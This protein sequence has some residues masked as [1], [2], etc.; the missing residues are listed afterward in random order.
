MDKSV[1]S[2]V[3]G[4]AIGIL[5]SM[6]VTNAVDSAARASAAESAASVASMENTI[7]PVEA[8]ATAAAAHAAGTYLVRNDKLYLVTDDIAIGD[9]ITA[10]TNVKEVPGGIGGEVS[11][12]KSAI[13]DCAVSKESDAENVD[14]DVTDSN[15]NVIMRLA[16]GHIKTKNFD[17]VDMRRDVD[18]K[19]SD[20]SDDLVLCDTVGNV[21]AAFSDGHFQTKKFNSADAVSTEKFVRVIDGNDAYTEFEYDNTESSTV[22]VIGH[23]KAGDKI[24]CHFSNMGNTLTDS[25]SNYKATYGFI[26]SGGLM[27]QLGQ[28]YPYNF[29]CYTLPEDTEQIVGI[30]PASLLSSTHTCRFIVYRLGAFER[31]P[32][33]ITVAPDGSKMFTG[34]R[35]AMDSITN[36]N[37]YNRYEIWVY[38]GTY[39]VMSEYTGDEIEAEG[40]KGLFVKNGVT[41]VGIGHREEIIIHGELDTTDYDQTKRNDI[42]TLN[43]AGCCGLKNLTVTN[44]YLRYAVHDDHGSAT[45]QEQTHIVENCKF[46][47]RNA[48]SGGAGEAAYGAGGTNNKKLI[49]KNCDLG[50]R[51]IIHNTDGMTVPMTAIIQNS[52]AKIVTLTDNNSPNAPTRVEFDNCNIAIIRHMLSSGHSTAYMVLCGEGTH[53]VMMDVAAGVLYNFGDCVRFPGTVS[54]GQAVAITNQMQIAATTDP[55]I[56]YGIAIGNDG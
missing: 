48:A 33:I 40:F 9:T 56:I 55:T 21:M 5:K 27:S 30:F 2:K 13:S 12:L 10:G 11:E 46:E 22:T 32:H 44:E 37:A 20:S 7:A 15:G 4:A 45:Y 26:N 29:P 41:L 43:M 31:Q 6:P 36:N 14:L 47:S 19:A 24:L 34:I 53:D 18:V 16:G 52:T 17:S 25:C 23:Y 1:N 8:T 38:P 39:N 28:D 49:I 50:E 51:L 3:M 35:A 54:A 42:S